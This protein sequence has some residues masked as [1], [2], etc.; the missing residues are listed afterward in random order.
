[1]SKQLDQIV[2]DVLERRFEGLEASLEEAMAAARS[3]LEAPLAEDEKGLIEE[4]ASAASESPRAVLI[5]RR[6]EA[7]LAAGLRAVGLDPLP[8]EV[9]V[10]EQDDP[11]GLNSAVVLLQSHLTGEGR[12]LLLLVGHEHFRKVERLVPSDRESG[13]STRIFDSRGRSSESGPAVEMISTSV[14]GA[15]VREIDAFLEE[16]SNINNKY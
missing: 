10:L 13:D 6:M 4:L 5:A 16:A 8:P 11:Q 9:V 15:M 1:M 14:E 3:V 12:S 7:S 2:H